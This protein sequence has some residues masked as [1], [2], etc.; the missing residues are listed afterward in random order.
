[1]NPNYKYI[2]LDLSQIVVNTY[3]DSFRIEMM[4]N[5][6]P[7]LLKNQSADDFP[8]INVTIPL[9]T[10]APLNYSNPVTKTVQEIPLNLRS[11]YSSYKSTI[12][13]TFV[14]SITSNFFSPDKQTSLGFNQI[15]LAQNNNLET[16]GVFLKIKFFLEAN[17]SYFDRFYMNEQDLINNVN[18]LLF[19]IKLIFDLIVFK[20]NN[21]IMNGEIIN[22]NFVHRGKL[23]NENLNNNTNLTKK[24]KIKKKKDKKIEI[25]VTDPAN[26]TIKKKL[27]PHHI[28]IITKR[29]E[30]SQQQIMTC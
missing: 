3:V 4:F 22:Q 24:L 15:E 8:Y 18:S 28:T 2:C 6:D 14:S 11:T 5:F 12:S 1:M 23:M 7:L 21:Y 9:T 17:A 25:Q 29:K 20:Y 13:N 26:Q 30:R 16:R 27:L 10:V 19:L